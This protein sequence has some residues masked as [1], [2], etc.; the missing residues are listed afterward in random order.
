MIS[1]LIKWLKTLGPRYIFLILIRIFKTNISFIQL[2]TTWGTN[3]HQVSKKKTSEIFNQWLCIFVEYSNSRLMVFERWKINFREIPFSRLFIVKNPMLNTEICFVRMKIIFREF[4]LIHSIFF[5]D[6]LKLIFVCIFQL[7]FC[8]Y[9]LS[10]LNRNECCS[11]KSE[12]ID[13]SILCVDRYYFDCMIFM[14]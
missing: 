6:L 13:R 9:Q 11:I 2:G 4:L 5:V 1:V 3:S 14:F 12:N 10:K 8:F 7:S